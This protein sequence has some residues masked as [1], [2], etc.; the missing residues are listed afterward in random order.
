M[1]PTLYFIT[2]ESTESALVEP[3]FRRLLIDSDFNLELELHG[4]KLEIKS[5]SE[6]VRVF[7]DTHVLIGQSSL[8]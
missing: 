7:V 8:A 4:T 1:I 3:V 6:A 5:K 2:S